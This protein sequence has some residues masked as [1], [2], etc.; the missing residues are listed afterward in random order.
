LLG[1]G[2]GGARGDGA[3]GWVVQDGCGASRGGWGGGGRGGGGGPL[4][5]GAHDTV[6]SVALRLVERRIRAREQRF[7]SFAVSRKLCDP[8]AD[9]QFLADH[10]VVRQTGPDTLRHLDRALH[11]RL[12]HQHHELFAAI[13]RGTIHVTAGVPENGANPREGPVTLEVAMGVVVR[14]E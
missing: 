3:P 1:S 13:P 14:L 7:R 5:G 4:G 8:E 9:G 10:G 6:S 12:W 2:G 11:L